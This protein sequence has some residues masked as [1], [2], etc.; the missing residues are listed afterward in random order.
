MKE[1]N[2]FT[3]WTLTSKIVIIEM[4]FN[5]G[6][7]M[8]KITDELAMIYKTCKLYYED[9][10]TIYMIYV[11]PK[12]KQDNLSAKEVALLKSVADTAMHSGIFAGAACVSMRP[13]FPTH[14]KTGMFLE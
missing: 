14:A 10:N 4:S 9:G 13:E 5:G 12:G 2:L 6:G 8:K 1:K 3:S 11:Y 7:N